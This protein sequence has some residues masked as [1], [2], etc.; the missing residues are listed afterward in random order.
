M[1]I[2][3]SSTIHGSGYLEYLQKPLLN[4]FKDCKKVLFIPYARPSGLSHDAYTEIA[5]KGL[6]FL[7][8]EIIGI[9]ESNNPKKALYEA[10][11]IFVGGGNTFVLVN[12]LY[13][14]NLMQLLKEQVEWGTPYLGTSAGSNIC[15]VSMQT[16]ND[17]PIVQPPSFETMGLIPFN[18]NAHFLLADKNSTHKG[19]TRETRIKEFH[20]YNETPV[21][22]LQEGSW[23]KVN[24]QSIQLKGAWDAYWFE[25]EKEMKACPPEHNF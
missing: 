23:L 17:M 19:E 16:T 18:V 20:F 3:S 2:A 1:I 6:S 7:N 25:K 8:A 5:R 10:E 24:D 21:L 4:L 9:H 12:E 11:A 14:N 15:G 13:K 22:G